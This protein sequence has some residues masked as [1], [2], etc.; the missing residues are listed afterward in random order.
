MVS[1]PDLDALRGL[2]PGEQTARLDDPL[3]AGL[4]RWTA[5]DH[6]AQLARDQFSGRFVASRKL[7]ATQGA[8]VRQGTVLTP[9]MFG[10]RPGQA[11]HTAHLHALFDQVEPGMRL[12]LNGRYMLSRGITVARKADFAVEGRGTIV[13]RSGVPVAHGF[14]MLYFIE[15]ADFQLSS[16]TFD[17][18]RAGRV[19]REVPAH[20][21][22]FQSCRQFTCSGVRSLNAVCDG[23]ILFSATP[24]QPDTHCRAFRFV[25]CVADNCYRQGCSIID[26]HDGL[27]SGGSFTNTNGTAPAAGIDLESDPG[28][29]PGAI[30]N[31]VVRNV[32]FAGNH[33]YGLL[34]STVSRP[35]DIA[36]EDCRFE[37]NRA[38]AISWGA[39]SGRISRVTISG[40]APTATRGAIDVPAGDGLRQEVGITIVAPRFSRV[41]TAR[42]DHPLVYVHSAAFSPVRIVALEADACGAIAGLNR[43]GS[44]LEGATVSASLGTVDG[45][46]SVSGRGCTLLRNQVERF[47]G[48]VIVATGSDVVVRSNTLS[49]PRFNDGNGV[50]RILAPGAIIEDNVIQGDRDMVGIRLAQ[51]ART[52]RNNRVTG[53]VR[54]IAD[55]T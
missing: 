53:F 15:C 36:V 52:L 54:T 17:A 38:G 30:S 10:A 49:T 46:I 13:M 44:S 27:F 5:G 43:D 12:Q 50:V 18:N 28:V 16:L 6:R 47:F 2:D 21:I 41:T 48:S 32:R 45:A 33:G 11:D 42:A 9:E 24:A 34:V 51:A 40:F 14:W 1:V 31:I 26:G 7:A 35:S 39:T 22:N 3:R 23:F 20:S 8:W 55:R 19:P 29:P 37:D 4:F 25:D